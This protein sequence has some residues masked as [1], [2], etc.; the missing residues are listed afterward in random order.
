MLTLIL[1]LG[2]FL[3]PSQAPSWSPLGGPVP[4]AGRSMTP[5]LQV[6]EGRVA[7]TFRERDL[8]LRGSV[9]LYDQ[10]SERWSA[11]GAPGTCSNREDWWSRLAYRD[12]L[13][14]RASYE[15]GLHPDGGS[16]LN[17]RRFDPVADAWVRLG[18][19]PLSS[20]E[21]HTPDIEVSPRRTVL[22]AYQD[23]PR[24]N[25]PG[26]PEGAVSVQE[27]DPVSGAA[28]YI[29]S[30]GFSDLL[31]SSPRSKSWHV[32]LEVTSSGVPWVGWSETRASDM[33]FGRDLAA[34][35]RF[36]EDSG[37][38][39]LV[40]GFG[41]GHGARGDHLA[42]ELGPGDVPFAATYVPLTGTGAVRVF[43]WDGAAAAWLR[44]GPEF[45]E[46]DGVDFSPEAGYREYLALAVDP[47]GVPHVAY[48]ARTL[49]ERI[50]VRRYE[51]A[52]D[53]WLLVGAGPFSL[54]N[55]ADDYVSLDFL[56][57]APVVAFR[58]GCSDTNVCLD[59]QLQVW[60]HR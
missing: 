60:I 18:P 10:S 32:N 33:L 45:G 20:G 48:R 6:L 34:V 26:Q 12:Q 23:G 43:R 53:D 7:V 46:L 11:I 19:L 16:G 27:V 21:A 44:V 56:G 25:G 49:G 40:G 4:V 41:L 30:Q 9:R 28:R 52:V 36:D 37:G 8:G 31:V 47:A 51:A 57:Y 1:A 50:V 5:R 42:F 29:G 3:V 38:W 22:V 24:G 59:S 13:L 54:P 15:Y 17:L 39:V 55:G 58:H 14:V 2:P 35:A